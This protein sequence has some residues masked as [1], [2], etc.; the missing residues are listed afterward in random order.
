MNLPHPSSASDG[1]FEAAADLVEAMKRAE[2]NG[3][4]LA[5][6]IKYRLA[7]VEA[8]RK[9]CEAYRAGTPAN[10]WR[11]AGEPD[12]HAGHYDGERAALALGDFTDDEL[13]NGAFMNYDAPF[14]LSAVLAKKPGYHA[15]IIWM[16]AVKD[17][18]R[19][20]SRAL[21]KEVD[22]VKL[23]RQA[24][25]IAQEQVVEHNSSASHVTSAVLLDAIATALKATE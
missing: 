19:W 4:A 20:L 5:V 10:T 13:A 15:P 14:D 24:L 8:D 16:T 1:E 18:I 17:R 25:N 11:A 3:D 22:D 23:L 12:P 2:T 9:R 7:T 21:V 6:V